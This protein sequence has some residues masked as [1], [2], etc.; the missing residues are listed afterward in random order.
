MDDLPGRSA[1][2]IAALI[3]MY[4]AK[5]PP[6]RCLPNRQAAATTAAHH[7][8]DDGTADDSAIEGTPAPSPDSES[9]PIE[10]WFR[11]I[12]S[13]MRFRDKRD[14]LS[15][16]LSESLT[17][18][19]QQDG[20]LCNV[21]AYISECMEGRYPRQLTMKESVIVVQ[22]LEDLKSVADESGGELGEWGFL[23]RGSWWSAENGSHVRDGDGDD[24]G[25]GGETQAAGLSETSSLPSVLQQFLTSCL[26]FPKLKRIA[27]SLN[28][29]QVP[30]RMLEQEQQLLFKQNQTPSTTTSG[31]AAAGVCSEE[32]DL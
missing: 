11:L 10:S 4:R 24:D 16:T 13:H 14:D 32:Q 25:S 30:V 29:L 22:L 23:S 26:K 21:Y 2:E 17:D 8:A 27:A 3:S 31:T 9:S 19:G 5:K 1:A 7:P 15:S 20:D 28:P 18:M 6:L 12:H